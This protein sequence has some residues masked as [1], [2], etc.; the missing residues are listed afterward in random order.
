MLAF[1]SLYLSPLLCPSLGWYLSMCHGCSFIRSLLPASYPSVIQSVR[2]SASPSLVSHTGQS[3]S[4]ASIS[5]HRAQ[6]IWPCLVPYTTPA[7]ECGWNRA[8]F[9]SSSSCSSVR[10]QATKA[11][12]FIHSY[13]IIS[14]IILLIERRGDVKYDGRRM[15]S[16]KVWENLDDLRG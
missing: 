5:G 13:F 12:H 9:A 2:E 14:F 10:L 15:D 7:P 8:T 3:P 1:C 11:V 6:A 16:I 4:F